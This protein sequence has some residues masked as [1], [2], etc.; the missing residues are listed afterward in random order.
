ME[1]A[2]TR[3][4]KFPEDFIACV[5]QKIEADWDKKWGPLLVGFPLNILYTFV[6]RE[7]K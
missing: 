1:F 6:P 4:N 7:S 2:L 5:P 3:K